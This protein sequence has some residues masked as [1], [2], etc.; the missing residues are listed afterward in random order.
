[1]I[2]IDV[3]NRLRDEIVQAFPSNKDKIVYVSNRFCD[4]E[5]D[6][7]LSKKDI[8]QMT[9]EELVE[10]KCKNTDHYVKLAEIKTQ[11]EKLKALWWETKRE[12]Y[13]SDASTER[14]W[15]RTKDGLEEKEVATKMKAKLM[16]IS[17]INSLIHVRENEAHNQ[18]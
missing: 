3:L 5:L 8:I 7:S 15:E 1:M 11:K 13:K 18:F 17:S 14:A 12:D 2:N 10:E 16:K 6:N 9:P 4:I